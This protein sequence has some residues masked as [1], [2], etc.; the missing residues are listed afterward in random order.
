[1]RCYHPKRRTA[2]VDDMTLASVS[3]TMSAA[4]LSIASRLA[5]AEPK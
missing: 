1:M 5:W 3:E 4:L 2:E